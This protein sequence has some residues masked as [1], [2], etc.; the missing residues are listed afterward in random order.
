[1]GTRRDSSEAIMWERG[2]QDFEIPKIRTTVLSQRGPVRLIIAGPS[3]SLREGL[4]ALQQRVPFGHEF[5]QGVSVLFR[6]MS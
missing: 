2:I 1:M 5:S 6:E 3:Q 4:K